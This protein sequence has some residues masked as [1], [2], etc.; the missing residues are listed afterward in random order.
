MNDRTCLHLQ[1]FLK[2]NQLL[3]D[4][5]IYEWQHTFSSAVECFREL[6]DLHYRFDCQ[7]SVCISVTFVASQAHS[8]IKIHMQSTQ[9]LMI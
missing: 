9:V 2:K 4:G 6:W 3:I 1:D 7:C 8:A 5:L